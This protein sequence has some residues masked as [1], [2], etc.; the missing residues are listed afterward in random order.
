MPLDYQF[1]GPPLNV[2]GPADGLGLGADNFNNV[3]YLISQSGNFPLAPSVLSKSTALA[4]VANNANVVTYT[5]P[6]TGMYLIT[7]YEVITTATSGT[8]PAI[9]ATYTDADTGVSTTQTVVASL[10]VAGTIG[11]NTS[12]SGSINAK[13][14]TTIVISTTGYVTV[15]YNVRVRIA[16]LGN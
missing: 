4:Q 9:V 10:A 1:S 2:G 8:L 11:L 16:Y 5:V 3:L 12:A 14:G 15:T 6:I 7:G 13:A